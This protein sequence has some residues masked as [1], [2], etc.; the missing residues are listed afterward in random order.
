MKKPPAYRGQR[1]PP[2]PH[3]GNDLAERRPV[4]E[5]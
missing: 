1:V 2:G 5:G 3:A 4:L